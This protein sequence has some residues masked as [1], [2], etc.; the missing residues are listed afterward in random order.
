MIQSPLDSDKSGCLTAL[1]ALLL[2]VLVI[3]G[4]IAIHSCLNPHE[5]NPT[6]HPDAPEKHP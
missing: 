2:F 5:N 3:G 6:L 4:T 1:I